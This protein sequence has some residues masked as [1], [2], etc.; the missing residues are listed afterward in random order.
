MA[1]PVVNCSGVGLVRRLSIFVLTYFSL[2][3]SRRFP[4]R[5]GFAVSAFPWPRARQARL[6]H[7]SAL[8][9]MTAA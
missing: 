3:V 8:F 2:P 6:S 9:G 5:H 1:L 4:I 7:T